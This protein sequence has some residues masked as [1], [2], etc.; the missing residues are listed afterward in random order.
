MKIRIIAFM[1]IAG[2]LLIGCRGKLDLAA[3]AAKTGN[4][5]KA[6]KLYREHLVENPYD[7]VALRAVSSIEGYE[8]GEYDSAAT[9][10]DTLLSVY[11]IDTLG[12]S[13]ATYVHT[14]LAK[15]AAE[16]GDTVRVRAELDKI[17]E[18]NFLSGY[19][20]YRNLHFDIAESRF[21][22]VMRLQPRRV[23]AYIRMGQVEH[24]RKR[25]DSALAWFYRALEVDPG[26]ED[27]HVNILV[28]NYIFNRRDETMK[29]FRKL[30]A[31]RTK[32]YPDSVF[33]DTTPKPA[34][35]DD[36]SPWNRR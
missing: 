29:A 20:H 24:Y 21:K 35:L 12:V 34:I 6:A 27:A 18:Q 33:S 25:P 22:Q 14:M 31:L 32:L 28:E 3:I 36:R 10:V 5:E 13:V 23:E 19:W 11:A 8:L 9:H 26:N 2:S 30:R 16:R 17:A 4:W 7:I 15:R 1:L